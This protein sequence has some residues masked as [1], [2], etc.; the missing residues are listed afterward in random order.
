MYLVPY[1]NGIFMYASVANCNCKLYS[2]ESFEKLPLSNV[3]ITMKP[4]RISTEHTSADLENYMSKIIIA[5]MNLVHLMDE[6][7]YENFF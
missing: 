3:W 6:Y 1:V 5:W 7:I 2:G 4:I